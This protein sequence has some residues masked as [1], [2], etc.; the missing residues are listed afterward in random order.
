MIAVTILVSSRNDPPV[1]MRF[2]ELLIIVPLTDSESVQ[3]RG[4]KILA[5]QKVSDG[6]ELN[7]NSSGCVLKLL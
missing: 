2:D 7:L 3:K 4:I 1:G 5:P 6:M